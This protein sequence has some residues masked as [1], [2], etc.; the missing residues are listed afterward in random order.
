MFVWFKREG[1]R[2][3]INIEQI[4]SIAPHDASGSVCSIRLADSHEIYVDHS[5]A[6]I[7]ETLAIA[8]NPSHAPKFQT[9]P[10]FR[11]VK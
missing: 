1:L 2:R 8:T 5:L 9:P 6:N 7:E 11:E 3:L 10:K 4:V